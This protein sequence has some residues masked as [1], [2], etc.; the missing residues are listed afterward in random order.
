MKNKSAFKLASIS[1]L[2]SE[3]INFVSTAKICQIHACKKDM[4]IFST[5]WRCMKKTVD[6]TLWPMKNV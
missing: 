2:L 3:E 4:T 1:Y 6:I 5:S